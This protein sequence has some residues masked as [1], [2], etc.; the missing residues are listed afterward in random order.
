MRI[1][2]SAPSL[3]RTDFKAFKLRAKGLY[4]S[5]DLYNDLREHTLSQLYLHVLQLGRR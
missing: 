5:D 4:D 2:L 1:C 3:S